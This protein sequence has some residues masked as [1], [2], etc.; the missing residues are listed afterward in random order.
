M[1]MED[2]YLRMAAFQYSPYYPLEKQ[3]SFL[4]QQYYGMSMMVPR[5]HFVQSSPSDLPVPVPAQEKIPENV[6]Q[7]KRIAG[8]ILRKGS[9][10]SC[11]EKTKIG[12]AI[13]HITRLHGNQ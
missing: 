11:S 7:K 8:A 12:F 10:L 13:R 3:E 9:S 6:A 5:S 2:E 4:P 1:L